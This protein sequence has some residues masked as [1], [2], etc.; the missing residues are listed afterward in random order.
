MITESKITICLAN[1]IVEK[2]ILIKNKALY[3]MKK[4]SIHR[5][6]GIGIIHTPY[7]LLFV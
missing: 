7:G 3:I 1:A 4:V 5:H 6:Y 2:F